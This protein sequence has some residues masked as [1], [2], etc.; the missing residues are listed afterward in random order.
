[1][2]TDNLYDIAIIGG[3]NAGLA[4]ALTAGRCN[5]KT[6]VIDAG[7]PRNKPAAHSHNFFTRDGEAPDELR[8]IGREQLKAYPSV[9]LHQALVTNAAAREGHF[10]LT[11][12]DEHRIQAR[13]IIIATGVKDVLPAI[14]GMHA[15]WGNK[16]IHCPYCHGWELLDQPVAIIA[17]GDVLLHM[18][19]LVGNLNKDI[20][21]LLNGAPVEEAHRQKIESKGWSVITTPITA[22]HDH[23]DGI[24]INFADG[25]HIVRSAAYLKPDKLAFNNQLAAQL[26][27]KVS[28]QGNV[29]VNDMLE[30][31]VPGVLAAGD[32]VHPGMHFVAAA[33]YQGHMTA[34][35]INRQLC[36]AD[37]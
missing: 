9:E 4:A 3:S 6:I 24:R 1:M 33:V 26:G 22:V 12:G 31:S 17:S 30:T 27:C 34:M 14:E 13:R 36:E 2:S 18:A 8:R 23:A 5:R 7:A 29:V 16:I 25:I 37:F 10:E 21:F 20:T 35:F 15:L 11:I 19:M 28:E 32:V